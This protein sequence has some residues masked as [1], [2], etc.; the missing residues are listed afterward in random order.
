MATPQAGIGKSMECFGNAGYGS[1]LS[2]PIAMNNWDMSFIKRFPIKSERRN[3]EFRAEMYNIFNHTQFT[4]YN[5][6]PTLNFPNWQNG[7]IQ[8]TNTSLGRPT[9]TRN[10]R[11]MVMT[12]RFEF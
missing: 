2:M 5:T 8:Q 1:I 7:V 11:Q 9:A 10:P 4:G 12:L 3:L 6:S